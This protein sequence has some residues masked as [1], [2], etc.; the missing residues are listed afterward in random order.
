VWRISSTVAVRPVTS[1]SSGAFFSVERRVL[2]R[3]LAPLERLHHQRGR[4]DLAGRARG[5]EQLAATAQLDEVEQLRPAALEV[6]VREGEPAACEA[7]VTHQ[8]EERAEV[9]LDLGGDEEA[10]NERPQVLDE[11]RAPRLVPCEDARGRG[12]RLVGHLGV[13]PRARLL[14]G[15]RA[16][17]GLIGPGEGRHR[18]RRAEPP[19]RGGRVWMMTYYLNAYNKNISYLCEMKFEE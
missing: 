11:Q 2:L 5:R 9:R 17:V 13:E 12:R 14:R 18:E 1:S 4:R 8:A 3:R 7:K 15:V 10:V 6:A 19:A 16:L